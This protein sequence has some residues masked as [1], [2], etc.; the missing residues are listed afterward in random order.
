MFVIE[1]KTLDPGFRRDDILIAAVLKIVI[2]A[3]GVAGSM[4]HVARPARGWQRLSLN[5]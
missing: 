5:S 4:Q 2:R 3:E 1:A